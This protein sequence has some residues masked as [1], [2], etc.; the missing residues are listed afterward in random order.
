M[1]KL[2]IKNRDVVKKNILNKTYVI[3]NLRSLL[4]SREIALVNPDSLLVTSTVYG[5]V[6]FYEKLFN[7]QL[8]P[9]QN[10]IVYSNFNLSTPLIN[11]IGMTPDFTIFSTDSIGKF[12]IIENGNI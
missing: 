12:N 2:Y 9:N 11:K 3:S 4:L 5:N 1:A 8:Q 7:G 6:L 10:Q